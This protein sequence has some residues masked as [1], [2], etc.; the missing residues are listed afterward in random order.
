[1]TDLLLYR[2]FLQKCNFSKF[3]YYYV[4][5][6]ICFI[7][8]PRE[9][10][11]AVSRPIYTKFG[12][13]VYSCTRF[14]L[15]RACFEKSKNQVTIGQIFGPA[16]TFSLV[17]T[18]RLKIFEKSFLLWHLGYYTFQKISLRQF[19]TV[20]FSQSLGSMERQKDR[21]WPQLSPKPYEIRPK[22]VWS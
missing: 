16:L 4:F 14:I 10:F 7:F 22:F 12:T 21:I 5:L 20:W 2:R 13:N 6:S 1:M 11:S 8:F 3:R 18:K 17:V 19:R 9:L 15:S